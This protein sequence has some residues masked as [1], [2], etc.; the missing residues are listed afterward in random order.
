MDIVIKIIG[1]VFVFIGIVNLLKPEVMKWL[2]GF[3]KQSSRIY[4]AAIIRFGLA[5]VFLL[6]ARECKNFWVIFAF[7][8]LFI[9]SGL[10]I[11][12]LGAEKLRSMIEWLQA[13][14]ALLLRVL[15]LIV[16]VVGAVIIWAA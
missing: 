11:F 3:C 2:M 14:P 10:L 13:R 9:I 6:A 1:I 16:L 4:F 5:V 8:I 15:G 7:G 12:L